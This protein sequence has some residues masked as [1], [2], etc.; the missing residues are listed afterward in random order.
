MRSKRTYRA[1]AVVCGAGIALALTMPTASA[2]FPGANGRLVFDR[3]GRIETV[4]ANGTGFET[5]LK[6][7]VRNA[8]APAWSP[9]GTR[10]AVQR[11]GADGFWHIWVKDM[12]TG[13]QIQITSNRRNDTGP[14]WSPDGTKI[15][16]GG[17]NPQPTFL[18]SDGGWAPS[19]SPSGTKIAYSSGWLSV[20]NADG[21]NERHFSN[22]ES[23]MDNLTWSPDG[24]RIAAVIDWQYATVIITMNPSTGAW[25]N[26]DVVAD[27]SGNLDWQPAVR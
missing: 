15:A 10:I 26:D 27:V 6:V 8:V 19:W 17:L 9:E 21:T 3:A 12:V 5:G 11:L 22:T 24:R 18:T 4:W 14:A 2:T 25:I 23:F 20:M 13:T 1:L 7:A 16:V